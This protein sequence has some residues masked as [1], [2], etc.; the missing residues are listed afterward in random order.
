MK[1][2]EILPLEKRKGIDQLPKVSVESE[3]FGLTHFVP[4]DLYLKA[5]EALEQCETLMLDAAQKGYS[6]EFMQ[7]CKGVKTDN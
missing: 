5:V 3:M 7:F 4:A 6:S 2:H 1:S